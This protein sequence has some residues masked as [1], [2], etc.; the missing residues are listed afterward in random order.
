MILAVDV[1]NTHIEIGLYVDGKYQ[2][3]W[4]IVTKIH[5]TED[6][7][8]SHLH[9]FLSLQN[10]SLDKVS[11]LAVASVVPN[12]TEMLEKLSRKYFNKAAFI[13][14]I[15]KNLGI[16]IDYEPVSSVGADRIC[17]AVATF[18]KYG[19]PAII[20]DLGTATTFDVI[21]ENGVYLGGAIAPG[22]ETTAWG[23]SEKA[24]KLPQIALKFPQHAIGKNT[25]ES[26]QSGLM[27]GAV[28][29]IDGLIQLISKEISGKPQ[30]IA[31]GGLANTIAPHSRYIKKVEPNLVLDGLVT[32]FYRNQ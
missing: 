26:M 13:V 7:F 27:L 19:G 5:R 21:N 28:Q 23:L 2:T 15:G 24:S 11:T 30:I 25:E 12:V 1:G 20:V 17:N 18:E 16:T 10:L 29:M 8:V 9:S 6:E 14:D 4:R 31:T 22:L 3:S 32:L